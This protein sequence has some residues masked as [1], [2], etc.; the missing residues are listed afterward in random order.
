M[1]DQ[2][3]KLIVTLA[4]N[5][6]EA[7]RTAQTLI[8]HQK[9][10]RGITDAW[11]T[12][13]GAKSQAT[14]AGIDTVKEEVKA[15]DDL[16]D[17]L[18][19]AA[20]SADKL[21]NSSSSFNLG[22]FRMT[23]RAV[24]QLGMQSIGEPIRQLGDVGEVAQQLGK[25]SDAAKTLPAT[26]AATTVSIG[27]MEVALAPLL[28]AM[29]PVIV[30]VG[31]LAA[32]LKIWSD[33]AQT[34]ADTSKKL[35]E[36]D[37]KR[38]DLQEQNKRTAQGMSTEQN[39]QNV[40][41]TADDIKAA[42]D[43]L[44]YL[45]AQKAQTDADYARLGGSINPGERSRLGAVGKQQQQDIDDYLKHIEDLQ[46]AFK[47]QTQELP[48]LIK[49]HEDLTEKLRKEAEA[50]KERDAAADATIANAVKTAALRAGGSS[51]SIE[52]QIADD[53]AR[54]AA[55]Q[56]QLA[57]SAKL[58]ADEIKK[59]RDELEAAAADEKNLTDNILPYVKEREKEEQ[60]TKDADAASKSYT[61]SLKKLTDATNATNAMTAE[62]AKQIAQEAEDDRIQA[63]R[64]GVEADYKNRIDAAKRNEAEQKVRDDLSSK[65]AQAE[66]KRNEQRDKIDQDFYDNSLQSYD[67]YIA[68]EKSETN[69]FNLDRIHT[70]EQA[71]LDLKQLAAEGDVAGFVSRSQQAKLQLKDQ[72]EN[73]DIASKQRYDQFNK[74]TQAAEQAHAK[75]LQDLESTYEV[76]RNVRAQDA[77]QR[78]NQIRQSGE[79]ANSESA[80]LEQ[81]LNSIR[82][83]WRRDDLARQRQLEE[84]SYNE[85]IAIQVAKQ[86]EIIDQTASFYAQMQAA[87]E[88]VNPY[89]DEQQATM[90]S[91]KG[92]LPHF[93]AGKDYIPYDNYAAMLHKGERVLTAQE[94]T[95]YSGSSG[96]EFKGTINVTVGDVVTQATLIQHLDKYQ[97]ATLEGFTQAF[98]QFKGVGTQT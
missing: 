9:D 47:N 69:R 72:Q 2:E 10:I 50:Q 83:Q 57:D 94:N 66:A 76:E 5:Q 86:K 67:N 34:A 6:S 13:K 28:L 60:A 82:E 91:L 42:N 8:S 95:N 22:S 97:D 18:D 43:H 30:A 35:Y 20:K 80:R 89:A 77:E 78:I 68:T 39:D 40:K 53:T 24:N 45:I 55:I 81:E 36:E 87:S 56:A 70:L 49:E 79:A 12:V 44:Q 7:Q 64:A 4:T 3:E 92:L 85:R 98:K 90:D 37:K 14:A 52:G 32:I 71:S 88:Q 29:A 21:K 19:D 84:D 75:Q 41:L 74:E 63:Q 59:L 26:I 11:N 58:S 65:N 27:G 96:P 54:Q 61:D 17:S 73:A 48:K 38:W 51:K 16:R 1:A 15:V 23:G 31:A 62:R 46:N 93:A 25:L 33:A